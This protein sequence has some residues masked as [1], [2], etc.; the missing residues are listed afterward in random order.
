MAAKTR[1]HLVRHGET[2]FNRLGIFRG[3]FEVDL[4]DRGRRQAGEIAA[5]L[6]GEG[7]QRLY[8]GPLRRTRETAEIIGR[9]LGIPVVADPGFDNI[10]LGEWQGVPKETV[11][12]DWPEA[13]RQW[14][15]SPEHLLVPG[16]ETVEDVKRRAFARV[17]EMLGD[18]ATPAVLGIVTHRSV[19][20]VLASAFLNVPPP[21]FW[22]F[23]IDNAAYSVF[24][25]DSGG[26]SLV[27]WN[28]NAHL[29]E[30]VTEVF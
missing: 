17:S 25:H 7:I 19:M 22:K 13:W 30:R 27:S 16:G 12:R 14:Q 21:Y 9:A 6:K 23:Y 3:R 4:N 11:Q 28:N 10:M 2:E 8:A 1:I 5:A 26:F 24:D 20:K 29:T 18:P 15:T